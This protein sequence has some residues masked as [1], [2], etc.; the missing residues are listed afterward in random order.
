MERITRRFPPYSDF[1][2]LNLYSWDAGER[3]RLS[4]LN[5]N[6]VIRFADYLTDE[7]F[8]MFLG[9]HRPR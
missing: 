2:F 9:P 3:V 8:Y 5:G 4:S 7:P 1:N 6:L